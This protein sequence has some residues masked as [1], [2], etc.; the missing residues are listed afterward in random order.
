[1]TNN[2]IYSK[3]NVIGWV[4][5]GDIKL[6][7]MEHVERYFGTY[8]RMLHMEDNP[9]S[10]LD[11]LVIPPRLEHNYYTL[12][13]VGM[14][15][16]K[17]TIPEEYKDQKLERAELLINLPKDWK[18]TENEEN[19]EWYWP[20][21][22]LKRLAGLPQQNPEIWLD[23]Q[24]TLREGDEGVPFSSNTKLCGTILLYPGV[25]GPD[26]FYCK[27][28][29]GDVNFY[30]VIPLYNEEIDYKI[31]YNFDAFIDLCPD[32]SLEVVNPHR[33]NVIT[34]ADI[35]GYDL[36]LMDDY[37]QHLKKIDNLGIAVDSIAALNHMSIC[38]RWCIINDH[39]SN[40]FRHKYEK[41]LEDVKSGSLIDLRS[42]IKEELGGK[43]RT[44]Y[45][46]RKGSGFA[47]WY[48]QNN[49]SNPYVY[50]RDCRDYALSLFKERTWKSLEEKEAAYLLLPFSEK[51]YKY[52]EVVIDS[53]YREYLETEYEEYQEE[54]TSAAAK[55]KPE[56]ISS[57]SGPLFCYASDLVA[58]Q[59]YRIGFLGRAEVEK[60]D[61]GWESGFYFFTGDEEDTYGE[62]NEDHMGYYDIR[63]ICK[64]EPEIIQFLDLECGKHFRRDE[65]SGKWLEI[66]EDED[67]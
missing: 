64:L 28:S 30:Q 21:G 48:Y 54:K 14:S 22:L 32:E 19:E 25:F 5:S 51:I 24:H 42:F 50:I 33:L 60:D 2:K 12:V 40:P 67:E 15:R 47:Q 55:G 65:E 31:E 57:W 20:I 63:D 36:S 23:S 38:L 26:S 58:D 34:D 9:E 29:Q 6:E 27:T 52:M 10:P 17:M 16:Y 11:I 53:R 7:V 8:C 4:P 41:V 1:M 45:L 66:E 18:L 59:G 62:S 35:I 61:E 37:R 13:T 49:R 43:L 46:D 56:V 44:L 39:M 3:V